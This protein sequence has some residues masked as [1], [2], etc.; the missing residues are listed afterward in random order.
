MV[1]QFEEMQAKKLEFKR[2]AL[3]KRRMMREAAE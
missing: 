2:D 1:H 3:V